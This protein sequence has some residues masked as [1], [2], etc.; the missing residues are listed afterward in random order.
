MQRAAVRRVDSD[1]RPGFGF[2]AHEC[3]GLG[4]VPVQDIRVQSPD[5]A[6]ESQPSEYIGRVGFPANW[7]PMN[8]K[9]QS[10]G[11]LC[12]SRVSTLAAGEAV[13]DDANE[14]TAISLSICNI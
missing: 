2:E 14:M 12:E 10:W 3:A 5:Q 4:A 13:G 9:L 8:P 11:D 1:R 7:N 6:D